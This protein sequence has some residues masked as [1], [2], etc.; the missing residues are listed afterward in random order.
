ME[1]EVVKKYSNEDITV[2]WKPHVCIHS[3]ICFKGLPG[4]FDRKRKPWIMMDQG[5][6]E[7]IISQIEKC[8]SGAL[9]YI[10]NSDVNELEE[11]TIRTQMEILPNGPILIY[12]TI[13]VKDKEG[14]KTLK[15]K[16]TAFCRCGES[17]NKPFCDGTHIKKEFIG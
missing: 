3:T 17:N 11:E 12:G 10:K 14:H 5:T 1:N 13:Q 8:P 4:V 6:T 16:T 15:N 2:V 9:S 7:E